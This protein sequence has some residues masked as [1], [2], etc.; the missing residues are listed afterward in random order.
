MDA[1]GAVHH[2]MVRGIER[3]TIFSDDRDRLQFVDRFTRVALEAEARCFAWALL[4]NHA[5]L[6]VQRRAQP[7]SRLMA[8]LNTGYARWFNR[9]YERVGYLFQGRFRSRIVR[10]DADLVQLVRYVHRNPL[11]AGIVRTLKDLERYPW[12]GH[13]GLTGARP[14]L[15]IEA[16]GFV[17]AILDRDPAGARRALATLMREPSSKQRSGP[18]GPQADPRRRIE[19]LIDEICG[20][21][22][23]SERILL[24]RQR[25]PAV[26]RARAL[27]AY[28]AAA[29][30]LP[31]AL[32]A[33]RLGLSRAAITRA[34]T[35]GMRDPSSGSVADPWAPARQVNSATTSPS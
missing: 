16:P 23:L 24:S 2:I 13:G 3:R 12:C 6:V 1:V 11:E 22:N 33:R 8:R 9:R 7:I 27:V 4:G 14:P 32:L 5:H 31:G 20:R 17:L 19:E 26:S 18:T 30:G 25:G 10:D 21:L 15:P 34:A 35:R 29:E 28:R